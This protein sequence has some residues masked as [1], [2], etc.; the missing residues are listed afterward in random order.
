MT[1]HETA[2]A[3]GRHS[4]RRAFTL[5][6][7]LAAMAILVVMMFLLFRFIS[8]AQQAWSAANASQEIHEKARIA[9]DLIT[10]D[11]QSAVAR[12]DDVPGFHIRFQQESN[13]SWSTATPSDEIRFVCDGGV[14]TGYAEVPLIEVGYKLDGNTLRRA[15]ENSDKTDW[16]PFADRN[17]ADDSSV[18][19][20]NGFQEVIGEVLGLEFICYDY[21]TTTTP[22]TLIQR[23]WL[24]ADIE[25]ALPVAVEVRL[26]LIDNRTYVRSSAL[27]VADRTTVRNEAA[28]NFSKMV[29]LM[30]RH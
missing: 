13:G 26:R 3:T 22:E 27:P 29:F 24:G 14:G 6:E 23:T 18:N 25:T 7:L 2:L 4:M 20:Q 10:R 21:D 11:L 5:V 16:D 1:T 12:S 17:S 15:F 19:N 9:L 30:G 28:L 8:G